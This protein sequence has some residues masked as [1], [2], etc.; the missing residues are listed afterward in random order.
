MSN[1]NFVRI[2]AHIYI[3]LP[4]DTPSAPKGIKEYDSW[5]ETWVAPQISKLYLAEFISDLESIEEEIYIR[6]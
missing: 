2:T 4:E 3:D 1:E 5:Y 6:D